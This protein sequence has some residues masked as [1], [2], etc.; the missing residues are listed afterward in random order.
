MS[1]LF[2]DCPSRCLPLQALPIRA[3]EM[4]G[5]IDESSDR[6][7]RARIK[8]LHGGLFCVCQHYWDLHMML[9]QLGSQV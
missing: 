5:S 1:L 9:P 8:C 6:L 3:N 2:L 4:P 7:I